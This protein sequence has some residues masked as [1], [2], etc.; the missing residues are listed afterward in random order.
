MARTVAFLGRRLSEKGLAR[1][2]V[3]GRV[4][5]DANGHY[6]NPS[7]N[8]ERT[9]TTRNSSL[10]KGSIGQHTNPKDVLSSLIWALSQNWGGPQDGSHLFG[11]TS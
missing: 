2:F 7:K 6:M 10:L 1:V 9:A 3:S 11:F 4:V 5:D 8:N